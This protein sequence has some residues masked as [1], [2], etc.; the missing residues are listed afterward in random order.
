MNE[1]DQLR[2]EAEQLKNAIRV[3]PP[4][5]LANFNLSAIEPMCIMC[6]IYHTRTTSGWP[7]DRLRHD[8]GAGGRNDGANRTHS[9]AYET[10][11]TR[12]SFQNLRYALGRRIE[13]NTNVTFSF[14]LF[15]FVQCSPH[16][17]LVPNTFCSACH[18]FVFDVIRML[19]KQPVTPLS[20][21]PRAISSL[22]GGFSCATGAPSEAIW[23]KSMPCIGPLTPGNVQAL[24]IFR[25]D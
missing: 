20:P 3:K 17:M 8:V 21:R 22:W 10:H 6:N 24:P 1:L 2:A 7:Q 15:H 18:V 11:T 19:G 12:S 14:F 25:I 9:D 16:T 13:V 4:T 23:Q 5:S